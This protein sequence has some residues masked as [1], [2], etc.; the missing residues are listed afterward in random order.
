[1]T[2]QLKQIRKFGMVEQLDH[3]YANSKN[4]DNAKKLYKDIV[5]KQNLL[6]AIDTIRQSGA[7]DDSVGKSRQWFLTNDA[8]TVVDYL[9]QRKRSYTPAKPRE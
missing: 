5:S 6:M 8:D 3:I 2:E 7:G 9:R 1:M 4:G